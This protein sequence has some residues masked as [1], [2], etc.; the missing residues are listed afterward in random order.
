MQIIVAVSI[1]KQPEAK[2]SRLH[3]RAG[4]QLG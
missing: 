3:R 4:S 1:R 2:F